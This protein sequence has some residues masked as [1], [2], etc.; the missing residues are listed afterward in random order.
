VGRFAERRRVIPHQASASRRDEGLDEFMGDSQTAKASA[1]AQSRLTTGIRYSICTLV[2]RPDLYEGMLASFRERGFDGPDCEFLKVD[3]TEHNRLDA[4]RACNLFFLVGRGDYIVICHQDVVL[5]ADGRE[6]MDAAIAELDRI[7]PRWALFGNS[8]GVAPGRL[9]IRISDPHGQNQRTEALPIR[10]SSLDEN[11]IVVRR[12]ANLAASH[13]LSG[14]HL[15]GADLCVMA[16]IMGRT[17]YVADFH[18]RHLSGGTSDEALATS[19]SNF[20]N[21]YTRA[22]RS[23]WVMTPA[24]MIFLSGFAPISG[25]M[26]FRP[27][28]RVRQRLGQIAHR[29]R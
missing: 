16:D 22:F 19:R 14:F 21:K 17:A 13:D 23:R 3:N 10:V 25:A 9:A 8:G 20:V 29:R 26:N 4:Y 5:M 7:D 18:L 12:D 15:Y 1:D 11:L 24:A 2:T 27:I 6:R 28:T